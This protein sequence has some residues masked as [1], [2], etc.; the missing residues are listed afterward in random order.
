VTATREPSVVMAADGA[1]DAVAEHVVEPVERI[2]RAHRPGYG[3]VVVGG[4]AGGG[5]AVVVGGGA[6]GG[7]G[8][9]AGLGFGAGFAGG[10]VVVACVVVYVGTYE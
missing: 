10:V 7:V 4:G 1:L 3:D 6:G 2:R 5:A 8:V 9:D